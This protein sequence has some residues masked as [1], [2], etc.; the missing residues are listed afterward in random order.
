M[1]ISLSSASV[2]AAGLIDI[3][4]DA[5]V[6]S[7]LALWNSRDKLLRSWILVPSGILV[8]LVACFGV[9]TFFKHFGVSFPASVACMLLLFAGLWICELVAGSHRTRQIVAAIDVPAGWSLRWISVF[10]TPTFV[11]LPLS[12]SITAGEVGKMI[13][14]FVIGFAIMFV[15]T[16]YMTR[17]LQLVTGSHKKAQAAR[18]EELG[19]PEDEIP[20]ALATPGL[21]TPLEST[22]VS[23]RTSNVALQDLAPPEQALGPSHGQASTAQI[24]STP[25]D[26]SASPPPL[27]QQTAPPPQR[28]RLWAAV[29]QAHLDTVT[30]FCLFLFVGL[31]IYYTISYAMPLQ[32][33]FT[34]LM[35]FAALSLPLKWKQVLHPVIVS[36]L[37]TVLGIWVF[38]LIH[39]QSLTP[40]LEEYTTGLKYLQIWEH[41]ATTTSSTLP[42]A[43]DILSTTLDASIV[44]LA[45]PMFQYRRELMQHFT[46]I[47]LPNLV[48]S[49]GSLYAYPSVCFAIGISATRSLAFASRSLTLALAIPATEN[50]GGD[51]NT[52]AAVAIMSGIVGA[53][54]GSRV[55]TFLKIP[56]D[57]YVTRGVTLGANSSAVATALLLRS[58]PRA[59]ALSSLSMSL[60]GTITV[61]F[62]SIP[63]VATTVKSLVGL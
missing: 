56:E 2:T 15:L 26:A 43:G 38:G 18:A 40:I 45:L 55:L 34:V 37:F 33:T 27:P 3:L 4:S 52:V 48:L 6:A 22:D 36:A 50:L 7:R 25:P 47:V 41:A 58:D 8:I 63:P 20:V 23:A 42:G 54:I 30:Y 1:A 24:N 11:V 44:S 32:L 14:V 51:R 31:P 49:I 62:T 16:A 39:R 46:A 29:V 17:G 60:F 35:Y 59:A 61:L 57:D 9:D 21:Q 13:A 12:P 28:A 53:L 19:P 5:L 10:F